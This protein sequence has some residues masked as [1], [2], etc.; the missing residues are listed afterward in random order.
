ME[1]IFMVVL[2]I[3]LIG[4][5]VYFSIKESKQFEKEDNKRQEDL[6]RYKKKIMEIKKNMGN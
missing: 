4:A 6:D 5:V 1:Q 2:M 3:I